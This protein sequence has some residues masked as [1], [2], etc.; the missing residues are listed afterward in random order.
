LFQINHDM[1]FYYSR[2]STIGQNSSRQIASFKT[3]GF[4]TSS[5]VFVDKIQ[6]NIPFLKRPEAIKLF[7]A[8][9]SSTE[10]NKTVVIDSIDRLGRNLLDILQTIELFSKNEI[11][12]KSLKEGFETFVNGKE[13]PMAKM[14]ISVMG[15]IAEME[16]NRIKERQSEGITI[17]KAEGKFKGRKVGSIQTNER[18]LQRHPVIV[19]KL[20]KGLSIRDVSEITGASTT[21]VNKVKKALSE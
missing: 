11:C 18:L 12:V 7:D 16:R 3:H 5:N 15:S 19:Q 9:T 4:V 20:K 6:G 17:A 8:V 21:T 14:V 10:N 2:V 1:Y 13:N